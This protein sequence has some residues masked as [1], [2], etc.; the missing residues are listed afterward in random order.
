MVE[1][2]R[3]R[4]VADDD[5][6][7][8]GP[9][10]APGAER[11]EGLVV[12]E[13][14]D[15][16][17]LE[18][19][20]HLVGRQAEVDRHRDGAELLDREVG[21]DELGGV[22]QEETDPVARLDAPVCETA[23]HGVDVAVE[24]G[25]G[26]LLALGD[27]RG[28]VGP[29]VG[30][31]SEVAAHVEAAAG[32][33]AGTL[34]RCRHNPVR[35]GGRPNRLSDGPDHPPTMTPDKTATMAE[36]V[37]R[38]EPGDSVAMG[39]ALEHAIPFA[40]GHELVRQGTDD[41]T[42]IGPISDLLFDQL[43]GAGLVSR[44]RAAW[45]GNVS[46]GTGYAFRRAVEAGELEVEDH[47]NFSVALALGA[48]AMGVPYLPTRSLLGSDVF[49]RSELFRAAE[50]PFTGDRVALVPAIE[51]DWAVVHV[52]RASPA[53]DAHLW[54]NTGVTQEAVGAADRVLLTAEAVVDDAV[55][56]SDPSRVA[57]TRDRVAAVVECPHGA[58]PS[59]LAGHYR[60]DHD[61]YLDYHRR[62]K[63]GDYDGWAE[64][65]IH[66]VEDRAAY[67][68]QIEADLSITSPSVAAEVRYGH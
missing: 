29:P 51:P 40:A 33:H 17:V 41:L 49:E 23:G 16:G 18:D 65:W 6:V 38:I 28:P 63:A 10:G 62:T 39:L 12:D 54:G 66:G 42:L 56:R 8:A 58:H 45:V 27:D 15:V 60:R 24:G 55:I 52:Q 2:G 53:G 67:Y 44:V 43:V 34:R 36:A 5:G 20:D 1:Q 47:S 21:E 59:P 26:E 9:V 3:E 61:H 11:A 31:Q 68:E 25:V 35:R 64:E 7:K 48:G 14:P 30:D 19:V 4:A 50:D 57:I 22:R 13:G 37:G 46:A 32:G